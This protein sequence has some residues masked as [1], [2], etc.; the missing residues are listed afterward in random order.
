MVHSSKLSAYFRRSI[1]FNPVFRRRMISSAWFTSGRDGTA[2]TWAGLPSP[3]PYRRSLRVSSER[4]WRSTHP[5]F[6]FSR[7]KTSI[8]DFLANYEFFFTLPLA[9]VKFL[10]YLNYAMMTSLWYFNFFS[11]FEPEH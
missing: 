7:V 6:S 2:P 10:G 8:S 3:S 4:S 9:D 1:K 5:S 11:I